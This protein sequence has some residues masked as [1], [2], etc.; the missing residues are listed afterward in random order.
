MP[1]LLAAMLLNLAPL[2]AG[3]VFVDAARAAALL[4]A[5]AAVIDARGDKAWAQGH[6]P[7][8][9]PVAWTSIRAGWLRTGLLTEDA[10]ALARTFSAAGVRDDA[11][12][13]VYGAGAAGWGEEGRLFWT[14]EYLG[15]G[16]VHV[17]DGGYPAWVAAGGAVSKAKD[18]VPAGAFTPAPVPARRAR[19]DRVAAAVSDDDVVLWDTRERREYDGATPYGEP[20]GGHIP[21]AVHLWYADLLAPDGT[22]LPTEALTAALTAQGIT[23]DKTVI[24]LC[25][26]GVRS[27]FGYAVLRELGYPQVANYDGSMWEWS[28]DAARPLE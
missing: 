24:P 25:T 18:P 26:G 27:G 22:L 8:S 14:L 15:H 17:L 13:L 20:R 9:R 1:S 11:P 16:D 28:A 7:G 2:H 10:A 23:P 5:G 21:G 4:D 19:V 6:L 3:E 12:V